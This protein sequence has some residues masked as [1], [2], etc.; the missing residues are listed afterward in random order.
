MRE[1]W[2]VIFTWIY[3]INYFLLS[4]W[5]NNLFGLMLF[6]I[7]YSSNLH[8]L[9]SSDKLLTCDGKWHIE[10]CCLIRHLPW[11]DQISYGI[12]RLFLFVNFS[13]TNAKFITIYC[14][15]FHTAIHIHV[16][17][18]TSKVLNMILEVTIRSFL[19]QVSKVLL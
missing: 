7:Y 14:H 18:V 3:G 19:C 17:N 1:M 5:N 9:C 10:A 13:L 8:K 11:V 16:L 2:F 4:S 6:F 12:Q 15:T